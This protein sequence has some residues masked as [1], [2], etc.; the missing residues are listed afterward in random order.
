MLKGK[1]SNSK[2]YICLIILI[3]RD[4]KIKGNPP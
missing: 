1:K 4:P 2:L 3:K